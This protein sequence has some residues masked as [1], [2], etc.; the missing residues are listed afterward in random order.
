MD[1]RIPPSLRALMAGREP[2]PGGISGEDWLARLPGLIDEHLERWDL[3]LDGPAWHGRCALVLP[4]RRDR[5]SGAPGALKIT[6]P[7]EEARTE[8][9]ALRLWDG[10][11]AVRLEAADPAALTLLLE[12]L[13][14]DRDLRNVGIMEACEAIGDLLRRLDRPATPQIPTIASQI[15][16]WRE[17]LSAPIGGVPRRLT[18]QAVSH[19]EDL[20]PGVQGASRMR[21]VHTD[22]HFE[23]ALA[24]LPGSAAT[25]RGAWL[26]IDPKVLAG[27]RAYAVAPAIWN[28]PWDTERADDLVVHARMRADIIGDDAGLDPER[29]RMWTLV[30]LVI[31]AVDAAQEGIVDQ[32]FLTR[33]IALAKAFTSP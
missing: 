33:M 29:V 8:H 6:W 3:A 21:L 4:V 31:N 30:R 23:N 32:E 10:H 16:H 27:E 17:K 26:A 12:R 22:L 7:H 5:G 20:A 19:L 11:G 2:D 13:D 24:P 25:E 28:R 1:E 9:L 15:P 18:E 14:G